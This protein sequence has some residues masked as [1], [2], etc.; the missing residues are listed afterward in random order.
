LVEA[1][2]ISGPATVSKAPSL[3]RAIED[4]GTLTTDSTF[5]PPCRSSFSAAMLSAVS[6]DWLIRM[7]A[8]P[9]ASGGSR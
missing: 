6:P 8:P 7:A 1:T 9:S 4:S 5:C 3:S 2:P